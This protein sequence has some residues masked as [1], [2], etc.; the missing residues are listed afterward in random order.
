MGVDGRTEDGQ[1]IIEFVLLLPLIMGITILMIRM[2]GAIQ[3]S[4][5]NQKYA[6][7]Q[8]IFNTHNSPFYPAQSG[9]YLKH[10]VSGMHHLTLG[11]A[12]DEIQ[13]TQR[14]K[15]VEVTV[16]RNR[17]L[18]SQDARAKV[19]VRTTVSLCSFSHTLAN[20]RDFYDAEALSGFDKQSNGKADPADVFRY[21]NSGDVQ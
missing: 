15:A 2:N 18:A 11:V 19:K 3:V 14:P 16:A 4:I 9:G 1:S 20:G 8:S 10:R 17:Q 12:E 5:V 21:C 6:R 13:G 7:L